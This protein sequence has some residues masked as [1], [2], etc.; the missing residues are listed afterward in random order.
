[1]TTKL[2]IPSTPAEITP[3]WLTDALRAGGNE[4]ALSLKFG[5]VHHTTIRKAPAGVN[6]GVALGVVCAG[7]TSRRKCRR[8][9]RQIQSRPPAILAGCDRNILAPTEC[10]L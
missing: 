1:M 5:G 10:G 7:P 6:A 3:E 2:D 9:W 4:R 8:P